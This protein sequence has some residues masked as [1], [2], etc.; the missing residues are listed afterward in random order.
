M[1][2]RARRAAR[3][4]TLIELL[5]VMAIIS[6]LASMLFP[7][8]AKARSKA[9]QTVCASNSKQL[10]TACIMYAGDYDGRWP[11]MDMTLQECT[12]QRGGHY[13]ADW[14]TSLLANWP[15]AIFPYVSNY[16]VYECPS[17]YGRAPGSSFSIPPLSYTFNGCALGMLQDNAPDTAS[18]VLM[19]D[20]VFT[21]TEARAN[22]TR[23]WFCFYWGW[24][25][26][27]GMYE[28]SFQDG[29]VKAIPETRVADHIWN[30]P[31]PNMF[32]Y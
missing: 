25:I 3:G 14:T 4:F 20:Q 2:A 29:H 10:A 9:R 8:F 21:F 15:R 26:H 18:T 23:T 17:S 30:Q 32:Y 24:A 7:S 5:V 31:L 22:P 12:Y 19:W 13:V 11:V 27:E 16:Q 6:I 28:C 1:T